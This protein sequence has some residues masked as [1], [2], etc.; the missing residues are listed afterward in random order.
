MKVVQIN[1]VCGQGST[2]RICVAVSQL[3]TKAGIENY[4]LYSR[5]KSDYELGIKYEKDFYAKVQAFKEKMFGTYGFEARYATLKLIKE[6]KRIKPDI[7]HL[8]VLHSHDCNLS[9]LFDYL[10]EE[11]IK[12]FWTLHDCWSYTAYCTHYS[13]AK[14][15]KWQMGKG[16]EKC[17]QR[18][19]YS[20][21]LDRSKILY[22][23]K[24]A[25]I[26]DVDLTIITPSEW[27][28]NE[29]RQSFMGRLPIKVIHNGIDLNVFKPINGIQ[30]GNKYRFWE[31]NN[32]P[33]IILGCANVWDRRKGF[34]D[35]LQL[36]E[37]LPQGME[38]LL[39]GL[40]DAQIAGLPSRVHGIAR[41]QNS[42][43]LAELYSA[44]D[45]FVNLTYEDNY[46]TVNLEAMACGTPVLT[47]R[48]GGS[49]ESVTPDT[50]WI[51]EQGDLNDVLQI[52]KHLKQQGNE[53]YRERC[54]QKALAQFDEHSCFDNYLSLYTN[55]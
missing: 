9:M 44:A 54:L 10:R 27:L 38:I 2:G 49:V 23:R 40:N 19:R 37:M 24:R 13:L 29:V 12:V 15:Y 39:V 7:V 51:V 41:T 31:S 18:N 42:R 47:Y 28:A 48:T 5:W 14:C 52:L 22:E 17:P 55:L 16:C 8:H 36:S 53:K 30:I 20:W 1:S 3:L 21:F 43:E 46:P 32:S 33:F 6:L 45:V 34:E 25:L 50:G 26:H 35:F 11:N 4:I